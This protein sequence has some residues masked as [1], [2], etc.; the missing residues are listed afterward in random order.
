[1]NFQQLA[2][3]L[4]RI[5][6]GVDA[7]IEECGEMMPMAGMMGQQPAPQA[8]Q[9]TVSMNVSMNAQGKGGI[10][11]LMDI[12][13]DI[14]NNADGEISTVMST[15]PHGAEI[16]A[17]PELDI[18]MPHDEIDGDV[19]IID[20]DQDEM[21]K[22]G[23]ANAPDEQYQSSEYMNNTLA[24]GANKPQ[25][26]T[27]G[28]YGNSDNPLTMAAILPVAAAMGRM[29]EGQGET[30]QSK[31]ESLYQEIKLREAT[32]KKMSRAAKGNEKYGKDGMKSLAKAGREGKDLDK[33]RDKYNKYD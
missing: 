32:D 26:M 7:Q 4:K 31:L 10:R 30:L 3:K 28:G 17:D 13:K 21:E 1:M 6:E 24:G 2:D 12:L 33:V 20:V 5:D 11:N 16:D 23:F 27:K 9:D 22:E 8:Q 29:S 14:E 25:K 19:E 15:E 18:M